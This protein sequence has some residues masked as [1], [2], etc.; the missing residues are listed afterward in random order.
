LA[1]G[2]SIRL[3]SQTRSRPVFKVVGTFSAKLDVFGSI[4]ITQAALAREFGQTQDTIDFVTT[5]PGADPVT[6][7]AILTRGAESA[8]PTAEVLNQGELKESREEQVDQ[9]VNL[10]LALLAMAVL[11]S[12]FASW[13]CC[14]RSACHAN[15]CGR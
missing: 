14:G 10:V 3:L 15:R 4:L 6:V 1:V 12:L 2:D 8:F 11:I 7:Q 9:L 5:E 13:G